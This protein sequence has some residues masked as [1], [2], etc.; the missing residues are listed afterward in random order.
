M[1][2]YVKRCMGLALVLV[3]LI[4]ATQVS[5]FANEIT[6]RYVGISLIAADLDISTSGRASCYGYANVLRGYSADLTVSLQRDGKT[7]K[8]WSDSGEDEVEI[9]GTYYVTPGH[10]Y[11]VVVSAVVENSRGSVVDRPT[12]E[13]S[14]VEY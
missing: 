9:I 14:V 12:M 8:S 7:I 11:Q 10:D 13:S 3:C 1:K 6:P 2:R 5:A 4:S